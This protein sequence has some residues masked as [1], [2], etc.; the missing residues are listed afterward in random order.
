MPW[1]CCASWSN[2]S[3]AVT[4]FVRSKNFF[5]SFSKASN[6]GFKTNLLSLVFLL[7]RKITQQSILLSRWYLYIFTLFFS[8]TKNNN[9]RLSIRII[10]GT[11][12]I[13]FKRTIRTIPLRW[14]YTRRNVSGMSRRHRFFLFL[15]MR[16]SFVYWHFPGMSIPLK[17][18]NHFNFY[19][20]NKC[21][22]KSHFT[23]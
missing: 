5:T 3:L 19:A 2:N 16:K 13:Q 1:Y 10:K 22:S 14:F 21:R 15:H 7:L 9:I 4:L 6:E 18:R 17:S 11:E 12:H 23:F 8:P 20:L